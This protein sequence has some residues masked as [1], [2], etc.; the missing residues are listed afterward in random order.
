[1]QRHGK[2]NLKKP[3]LK[4]FLMAQNVLKKWELSPL[5]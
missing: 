3:H 5:L 2:M 4:Q 1:M